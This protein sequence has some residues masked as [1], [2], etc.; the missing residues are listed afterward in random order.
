MDTMV[1]ILAVVGG[2]IALVL[3]FKFVAGCLL[4]LVLVAALIALV[5]LVLVP[6]LRQ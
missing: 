1:L 2:I 6:M 4:R 3:I 5:A